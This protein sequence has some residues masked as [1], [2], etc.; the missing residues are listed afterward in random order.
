MRQIPSGTTSVIKQF[1]S[2]HPRGV[3]PSRRRYRRGDSMISIHAPAWGATTP[4]RLLPATPSIS[5]HAPAWGATQKRPVRIEVVSFQSTHPRGVRQ[6]TG[7]AIAQAG[8]I[9]IHAPAWGATVLCQAC[10]RSRQISIHA[11]AWGATLLHIE[12]RQRLLISIHAP[13]WGATCFHRQ[14]GSWHSI[15]IHA[16]AW[17]ATSWHSRSWNRKRFQS[18]HPR[19]VR[20]PP[21]QGPW[22]CF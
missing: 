15:S 9:S 10:S 21:I 8:D 4:G 22:K 6:G 1:Q 17:G 19:G 2:T 12:V 14:F 16:P 11:P 13:A 7:K 20:P 3:R 18:T 5:I